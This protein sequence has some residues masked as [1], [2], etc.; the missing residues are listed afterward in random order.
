MTIDIPDEYGIVDNEK[1]NPISRRIFEAFSDE[2]NNTSFF[3]SWS[4]FINYTQTET[5]VC[6]VITD[7][8]CFYRIVDTH[9]WM[10]TRIKYGI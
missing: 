4:G 5:G 1:V 10:L 8:G 3:G 7:R 9:K 2:F 6:Y